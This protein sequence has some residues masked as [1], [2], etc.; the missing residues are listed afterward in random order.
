MLPEVIALL[1]PQSRKPAAK[2]GY[3]GTRSH[4]AKPTDRSS[5]AM[6]ISRRREKVSAHAPEGTSSTNPVT[7]QMA[8]S[9]EIWPPLSPAS[10]N[11]SA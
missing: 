10:A 9:D 6:A 4:R 1:A 8:N 3:E 11:S 5:S 2:P 7:D